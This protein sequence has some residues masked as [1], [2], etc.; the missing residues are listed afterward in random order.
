MKNEKRELRK[1]KRFLPCLSIEN[2]LGQIKGNLVWLSKDKI[3]IL[4]KYKLT[5]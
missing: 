5:L 2:D 1:G 4:V 3:L